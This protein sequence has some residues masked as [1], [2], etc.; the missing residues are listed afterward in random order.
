MTAGG[1]PRGSV[2]LRQCRA[3]ITK[4]ELMSLLENVEGVLRIAVT[5]VLSPLLRGGYNRWGATDEEVAR[6]L[7]GDDLVAAP[8]MGYTRA[9]TIRAP[10]VDIWPWLAQIG[11][12]RGGFYSYDG[13]ENLAGCDIHSADRIL[14]EHQRVNPGDLIRL[15]PEGYPCQ[16][17]V[18]ADPPH[19]LLLLGAD[20]KTGQAPDYTAP[21]SESDTV[22]SWLFYLDER[23]DGTTRLI[24]RQRLDYG[25]KLALLWRMVEPVNF[26][27]ERRMLL[28]IKQRVEAGRQAAQATA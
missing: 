24:V 17:V 14:P 1:L 11:Q 2:A 10:A 27:M 3:F 20:P 28:G 6:A 25:R 5:L 21:R 15:G 9:I 4:G 13:L 22:A 8:R 26:V 23:S 16:Q 7:P 12:G 18:R 19:T